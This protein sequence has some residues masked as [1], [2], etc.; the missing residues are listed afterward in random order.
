MTTKYYRLV[1][2]ALGMHAPN[3][4]VH[5]KLNEAAT[6]S[7]DPILREMLGKVM[8]EMQYSSINTQATAVQDS[9]SIEGIS[10]LIAH[11]KKRAYVDQ[12]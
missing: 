2:E 5:N 3:N 6:H 7:D 11:C 4:R 12:K 9:S 1:L 10:Q 8:R